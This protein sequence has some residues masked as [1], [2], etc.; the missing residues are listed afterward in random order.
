[1]KICAY[2]KQHCIYFFIVNVTYFYE[3]HSL[4]FA[5]FIYF[6]F[7]IKRYGKLYRLLAEKIKTNKKDK[8]YTKFLLVKIS[9][10]YE[11]K[12]LDTSIRC[13]IIQ[14]SY[15]QANYFQK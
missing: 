13:W 11:T 2:T 10:S 6:Y 7:F 4:I 9:T 15:G 5:F 12:K 1:M 3:K 14:T 8:N